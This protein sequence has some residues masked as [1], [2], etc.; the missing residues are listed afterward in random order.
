MRYYEW[1]HTNEVL[2]SKVSFSSRNVLSVRSEM[3]RLPRSTQNSRPVQSQTST[4]SLSLEG[5]LVLSKT[6][7]HKTANSA[8]SALLR[9][10][11]LEFKIN[12]KSEE[13]IERLL[14]Q[15][16]QR[17][18][19]L[20][21]LGENQLF[22]RFLVMS[23]ETLSQG[24]LIRVLTLIQCSLPAT[25]QCPVYATE[26]DTLGRYL[27][28]YESPTPRTFHKRRVRYIH[29]L[30]QQTQLRREEY[31]IEPLENATMEFDANW[32]EVRIHSHT[33]VKV[34]GVEAINEQVN[35][36]LL[37]KQR[38]SVSAKER[39]A[40]SESLNQTTRIEVEPWTPLDTL[41]ANRGI[42]R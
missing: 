4:L 39:R 16:L 36:L 33:R 13:Q 1:I 19:L 31:A 41:A 26:S 40:I 35:G 34:R 15:A 3:F 17:F 20:G 23:S 14:P 11:H 22:S 27:A 2:T 30:G 9:C 37:T 24:I 5:E 6:A 18:P 25:L 38:R 29:A 7:L 8:I 42:S 12:S 32:S 10:S 21:I 28:K